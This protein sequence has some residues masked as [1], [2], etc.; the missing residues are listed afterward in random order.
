MKIYNELGYIDQKKIYKEAKRINASFVVEIGP[1][2]CG[3]TFG[4]LQLALE[5]G[6]PFILMRRIKD[7]ADFISNGVVSPF[8]ALGRRDIYFKKE[9]EYTS[10]ILSDG[11]RLGMVTS[12]VSIAKIRGFYGGEYS[13]LI[14]DEFIPENHVH[15]IKNEGDAFLNAI[16]TISGN[17]ELKGKPPLMTWLLSNSNNIN[18]PILQALNITD[19]V[20]S[21]LNRGQ[22]YSALEDRGIIIIIPHCNDIMKRRKETA[23]VRAVGKDSRFYKMAFDNEFAYN[24]PEHVKAQ[25]L[26]EYIPIAAIRSKCTVYRHKD[27]PRIYVT[28]FRNCRTILP[29]TDRGAKQL[30]LIF[31]DLKVYYNAGYTFFDSLTTKEIYKDI[32]KV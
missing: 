16:I 22:E 14:Y 6:E 2:Q 29:D 24:D 17:R 27:K 19:K 13:M 5:L 15:R 25:P 26:G 3:K 30:L 20:E 31:P 18:S 4:S 7:E 32:I 11:N 8:L 10:A 23:L 12:L 21:M 1:R 28:A 9:S